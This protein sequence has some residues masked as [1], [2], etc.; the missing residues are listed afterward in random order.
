[1]FL[2][3]LMLMLMKYAKYTSSNWE[4]EKSIGLS[5]NVANLSKFFGF[6]F[7]TLSKHTHKSYYRRKADSIWSIS[8]MVVKS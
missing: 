5:Q 1:M 4:Y 2:I 6:Y 7:G 3:V 8:C